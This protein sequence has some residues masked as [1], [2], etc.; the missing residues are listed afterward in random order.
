MLY[1]TYVKYQ[2][3][4]ICIGISCYALVNTNFREFKNIM[5]KICLPMPI[6]TCILI[7]GTV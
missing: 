2:N 6:L 1:Y 5:L 7:N 3:V 4:C